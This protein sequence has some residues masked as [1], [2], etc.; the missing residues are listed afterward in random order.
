MRR[1]PPI[2]ALLGTITPLGHDEG[3]LDAGLAFAEAGVPI[4]FVT[5]PQ[6][7]STTP[8]TMAGSLTVG[9]AEAL[10][11]VCAIQAAIPGAPVF[12]CFIPSVMDLRSGDFSGGAPEDTLMGAAV[13]TSGRSTDCR[14]SAAS[15]PRRPSSRTGRR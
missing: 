14:R 6:G 7:G 5:M 12:I 15:T 3:T 11:G 4:G 2:S 13:G 9:I 8:L 10:S 1:A